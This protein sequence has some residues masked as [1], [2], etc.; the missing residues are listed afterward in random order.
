MESEKPS[1]NEMPGS[2]KKKWWLWTIL[3]CGLAAAG[4]QLFPHV[5]HSFVEARSSAPK[6]ARSQQGPGI[7]VV[8][9]ASRKGD[10]PVYL[11]GL[12]SVAAYNTVTART[13]VDGQLVKVAF[14][15][16]QFVKE[17][18]LLAEIDPRPFQ[19]QLEQAEGQMA[20]DQALLKNANIDLERYQILYAQDAIPKQQLD[21]QRS[22]VNQLEGNIKSDQAQIDD[23]KLQ[24]VYSRITSPL[25][26]RVGLRLVDQGNMVHANDANGL[27]V[28]T[29][30]QPIAVLF[31]IAEDYLPQVREKIRAGRT[32]IVDAYDRDLKHKLARGTLET[33]DNQVDPGTGTV[34]FKG[35]FENKDLSLFPNQF[36]NARLL[37]DTLHG[38]VIIPGAAIQRGTDST[39]VYVVRKDSTVEVR[40]ITVNHVEGDDASVDSGLQPGEMVVVDGIDKLQQGSRVMARVVDS[41]A[42][43]SGP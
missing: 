34:R 42:S 30:L 36:V 39:F 24:L 3:V 9:V 5:F 7:P 14:T 40:N 20:R 18:D 12:G 1:P 13:R 10:M 41:S 2:K 8:A 17:G 33:L 22:T 37:V 27:V 32:L 43:R 38:T 26:G 16:G 15:E 21:T 31:N 25:T 11:N 6:A 35:I 29:Q 4:Y 19:V 28:I 23:A